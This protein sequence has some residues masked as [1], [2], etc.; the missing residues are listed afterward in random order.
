ME[1]RTER[2]PVNFGNNANVLDWDECELGISHAVADW[3]RS[4]ISGIVSRSHIR[5]PP[6]RP[7]GGDAAME[8][9]KVKKMLQF[10]EKYPIVGTG[11]HAQTE[12]P[13]SSGRRHLAF[14][15]LPFVGFSFWG[16]KTRWT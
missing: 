15:R 2:E 3:D 7:V 9:T 4:G 5:A 8:R 6:S 1:P 10:Q 13:A 11:R 16:G 14:L 12:P